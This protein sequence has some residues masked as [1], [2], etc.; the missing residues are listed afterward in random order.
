[1]FNIDKESRDESIKYAKL[2]ER[3]AQ[4]EDDVQVSYEFQDIANEVYSNGFNN[5]LNTTKGETSMKLG[6]NGIDTPKVVNA[7]EVESKIKEADSKIVCSSELLEKVKIAGIK[8]KEER[9]RRLQEELEKERQEQE[10][11]AKMEEELKTKEEEVAQREKEL[12]ESIN[13]LISDRV[14]LDEEFKD[15][16]ESNQSEISSYAIE[17]RAK[18][19]TMDMEE[20]AQ[21]S[22]TKWVLEELE[23]IIAE[24]N[25][26]DSESV[27]KREVYDLKDRLKEVLSNA[28]NHEE[29]EKKSKIAWGLLDER[30]PMWLQE[31]EN[32][33]NQHR[34]EQMH[35]AK[36]EL[37][38]QIQTSEEK[39]LGAIGQALSEAISS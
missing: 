18:I 4:L 6:I 36:K 25:G 19:A 1:M 22:H 28:P 32:R 7:E 38:E 16:Y 11:I 13:T 12:I 8:F 20:I 30:K 24:I 37:S 23:S 2:L 5:R 26:I 33:R 29:I 10:R 39:Q 14:E 21:L 17:E 9:E 34:L 15:F 31:F 3:N 27:T 35:R